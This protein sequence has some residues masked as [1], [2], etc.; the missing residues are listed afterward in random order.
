MWILIF[1]FFLTCLMLAWVLFVYYLWLFFLS[2]IKKDSPEAPEG[3]SSAPV[4]SFIVPVYNEAAH[5]AQKIGNL[6]A[7]DY[8]KDKLQV[9]FVDGGSGDETPAV[10][11][12]LKEPYMELVSSPSRGKIQQVNYALKHTRGDFIFISDADG[13]VTP[14]TAAEVLKEFEKDRNICL[15]GVYSHPEGAYSIDRYYWLAQNKGRLLESS[16]FTSSIVV[17]ICYAFRKGLI[18]AFPD[19]VVADDVYISY[20]ANNLGKKVSYIDRCMAI[21]VRSPQG[22]KQFISH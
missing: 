13:I 3:V 14:N 1:L 9:I 5:I 10:I 11:N 17:A 15:V 18:D 16:A 12:R 22:G 2:L 4:L 19:D 7:L 8:P 6:K 20:R 21:E